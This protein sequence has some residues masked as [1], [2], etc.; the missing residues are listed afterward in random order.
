M[1]A[2][3]SP[4]KWKDSGTAEQPSMIVQLSAMGHCFSRTPEGPD[5]GE[6][7][8]LVLC[9]DSQTN[10]SEAAAQARHYISKGAGWTPTAEQS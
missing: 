3:E 4:G 8:E 7:G 9:F 6:A 1:A 5:V 2:G 10:R